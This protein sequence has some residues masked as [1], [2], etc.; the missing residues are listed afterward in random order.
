MRS[1]RS[2]CLRHSSQ[3]LHHL[4]P[5]FTAPLPDIERTFAENR[6]KADL[7]YLVANFV[8]AGRLS[9]R[10]SRRASSTGRATNCEQSRPSLPLRTLFL[11][12]D[13][14]YT[15][16]VATGTYCLRL[17][18]SNRRGPA[19]H[20]D[21]TLI[22]DQARGQARFCRRLNVAIPQN[23]FDLLHYRAWRERSIPVPSISS[24][25]QQEKIID[26]SC[27]TNER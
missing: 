22:I 3:D 20:G 19:S 24:A 14:L 4:L 6:R 17:V 27:E 12:L 7:Q 23:T 25:R 16:Y 21:E 26:I 10:W 11:E 15:S 13:D 5:I 8:T 9:S 1:R 18:I 2:S